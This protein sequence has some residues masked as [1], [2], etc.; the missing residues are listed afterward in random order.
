MHKRGNPQLEEGHTRIA[1]ELLE[2]ILCYPFT[3]GELKVVLAIIRLTYGWQTIE[4]PI[5]QTEL[6]RLTALAPRYLHRVL[7][8]LRQHGVLF[9]QRYSRPHR[10]A[11]NKHYT[12]WKQWPHPDSAVGFDRPTRL[13][14]PHL[15]GKSGQPDL[16]VSDA[17]DPWVRAEK[18][19]KKEKKEREIDPAVHNLIQHF[20]RFLNRPLTPDEA[21]LVARLQELSPT[22]VEQLITQVA[23]TCHLTQGDA[24]DGDGAGHSPQPTVL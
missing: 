9:R 16:E 10:Y 5:R 4:R 2:A 23:P 24:R 19:I 14:L 18:E 20:S 3:G 12:A 21:D 17:P 15:T 7:I 13:L 6:A 1:N 11:L 8:R 22:H